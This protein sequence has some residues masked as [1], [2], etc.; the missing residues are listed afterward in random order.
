[1]GGFLE[2]IQTT[3][4]IKKITKDD[5]PQ[6]GKELRYHLL[7]N[8]SKT[9]GHLA[10]NLGVVELTMALEYVFDL[11][12]DKIVWD[13]GHQAYIHKM[14][15]G[16]KDMFHS[17]RQLE[18]LSGFPKPS[19]SDADAFAAGHSSTSISAA[20]G[21]AK[22][23]DLKQ[24][25]HHVIAVIGDGSMTG[26]LAYEAMNNAGRENTNLIVI[27]NDNQ[28]SIDG[29]VGAMSKHL[30]ALRTGSPYRNMKE[31]IK[32]F[33]DKVPIF[34]TA[35]YFLLDKLRNSAK[36]VFMFEGAMFE[37]LG[38]RYIG[39]V[40]GHDI[41]EMLEIFENLKT[42][43]GPV[44][45][46]VKT[47]KG[48]G[49]RPAEE[50]PSPFH[51]VGAFDLKTGEL[52]L[53]MSG[54]SWSDVF[55]EK[56]LDLAK[57]NKKIVGITA[58]MCSGTGME[59]FQ[60]AYPKRFFDVGIAEQHATVF[61]AGLAKEGLVP[62]FAVYSSFLQ[63]AYDQLV[64]DVC[65]ENL[66]VIFAID[67]AG[68]VGA[69]GETHQGIFDLSYLSHIPN[70]TVLS[71]KNA[72]ELEEMLA[73]AVEEC[74]GPVAIRYPRGVATTDFS[75]QQV[76]IQHGKAEMLQ[77]EGDIAI[78][79]EGHMVSTAVAVAKRLEA[80]G[81]H[82]MIGNIRFVS[83]LDED[84]L[85]TI[86]KKVKHVFTVENNL[87]KGGFG[88]KVLEVYSDAD[89]STPVTNFAFPN[90]YIEQ[91]TQQELFQRYGLDEVGIYNR[92]LKKLGE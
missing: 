75:A 84:M 50:K 48:K 77:E 8:V 10:S 42:Q 4:D 69:D 92:I 17:L 89:I 63:R 45:I 22:A 72:W 62:V 52:P 12:N 83:P 68:I 36:S 19:E 24:E 51:G 38:F 71:P 34:G 23:R 60:S 28:M 88:S 86:A 14:L 80:N 58:A 37:S 18:G 40:D 5:L 81:I 25:H 66:H 49:Y 65:M 70:M 20:L 30:N 33:R 26:G 85:L 82:A 87:R 41:E 3:G 31:G 53:K 13:V 6:L 54:R 64:H 76:P 61:A 35:T 16:R 74:T 90:Q 91:G 39:P 1:M 44:L 55:G 11:P 2:K 47:T 32:D 57:D 29:N 79:A 73:Y 67:R 27:L 43:T 56:L 46:H 59:A 21:L 7:K 9:G 15:T 78:L